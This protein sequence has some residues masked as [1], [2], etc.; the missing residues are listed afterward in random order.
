MDVAP[1]PGMSEAVAKV[2]LGQYPPPFLISFPHAAG[3]K[4]TITNVARYASGKSTSEK[5]FLKRCFIYLTP[6]LSSKERDQ[7]LRVHGN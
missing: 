5:K 6:N 1:F 2:S 3:L 7:C 4:R